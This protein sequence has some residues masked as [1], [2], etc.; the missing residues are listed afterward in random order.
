MFFNSRNFLE[1]TT[2]IHLIKVL[3]FSWKLRITLWLTIEEGKPLLRASLDLRFFCLDLVP[4]LIENPETWRCP[5]QK[6]AWNEQAKSLC[7]EALS[8]P[9]GCQ[10]PRSNPQCSHFQSLSWTGWRCFPKGPRCLL[11]LRWEVALWQSLRH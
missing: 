11:S 3:S 1:T 8:G 9:S 10:V 6:V 2:I 4:K 7:S 5:K